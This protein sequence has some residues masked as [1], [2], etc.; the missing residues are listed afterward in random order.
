[1]AYEN[2]K[3]YG[4]VEVDDVKSVLGA[5]S[6]D[7]GT[8]CTHENV[9]W[10]SLKKPVQHP[11]MFASDNPAY[12]DTWYQ[13]QDTAE[14][15]LGDMTCG[16]KVGNAYQSLVAGGQRIVD[17]VCD[18]SAD[19]NGFLYNLAK[20]TTNHFVYLKPQGLDAGSPY[21]LDDFRGYNHYA[22]N[23]MPNVKPPTNNIYR[24]ESGI[25][26]ASLNLP[27]VT[28]GDALT[29]VSLDSLKLPDTM[30]GMTLRN[31]YYGVLLYNDNLTDVLWGTQ[32][33]DQKN[34]ELNEGQTPQVT[35][36]DNDYVTISNRKGKYKAR[37]FFST[38]PLVG[39]NPTMPS[40]TTFLLAS[41][42]SPIDV[43]V[44]DT[45]LPTVELSA[46]NKI[47]SGSYYPQA[48]I[49]NNMPYA[50]TVSSVVFNN[51]FDLPL[52][53]TVPKSIEAFG[54]AV[55]RAGLGASFAQAFTVKVV[56]D[57]EEY[58]TSATANDIV[59]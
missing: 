34:K 3:I 37:A 29:N 49:A 22:V 36:A 7:I 46:G 48:T 4:N 55:F 19:V 6:R 25:F 20:G 1:M 41:I 30:L 18:I 33:V 12:A 14:G 51:G 2:G 8:L 23:P 35:F 15:Y 32:T 52:D 50:V 47:I 40:G 16:L 56:V 17:K 24:Y 54:H 11:D 38:Q 45:N 28:L 59:S 5:S 21:R 42:D 58:T 10:A 27:D 53:S 39:N 9:N 43:A 31:M 13:G 57:G 44:L 26:N